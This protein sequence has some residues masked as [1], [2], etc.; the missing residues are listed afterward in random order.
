MSRDVRPVHMGSFEKFQK[1]TRSKFYDT[2]INYRAL[3]KRIG[4]IEKKQQQ[5]TRQV[6]AV[7][8]LTVILAASTFF[9]FIM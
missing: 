8:W 7:F 4:L 1:E 9:L 3:A 6:K 5:A 2:D